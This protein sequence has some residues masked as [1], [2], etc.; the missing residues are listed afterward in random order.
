MNRNETQSLN[1]YRLHEHDTG[2]TGVQIA[3]L[4]RHITLLNKH[5]ASNAKDYA[6]KTGLIKMVSRRRRLLDYLMK[7]DKKRYETIIGELGLRR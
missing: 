1:T 6:S 4:T 7:K 5:F 3:E 2:S